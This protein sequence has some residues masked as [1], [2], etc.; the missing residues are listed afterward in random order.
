MSTSAYDEKE[1]ETSDLIAKLMAIHA[2][3]G[4]F[5]CLAEAVQGQKAGT[6]EAKLAA[7]LMERW[8]FVEKLNQATPDPRPQK[9]RHL[10]VLGMMQK[11]SEADKKKAQGL[12]FASKQI[13]I[14]GFLY[15]WF[16]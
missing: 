15:F 14:N 13:L 5:K 8:N 3:G 11:R 2:L 1:T 9:P 16:F 6:D 10:A 4:N 7:D 12:Q